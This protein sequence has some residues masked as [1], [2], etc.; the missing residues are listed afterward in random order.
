MLKY[1]KENNLSLWE[2]AV[3]YECARGNVDKT[4]VFEKMQHIVRL[5]K[6]SIQK[7]LQGTDYQDRILPVQ[8]LGFKDKMDEKAL[9]NSGMLNT[10]ILYVTAMME[11]KSSMG[12]IVAAPTAGSCGA[13]PGTLIGASDIMQKSENELVKAM[14]AAGMIGVFISEHSTFAAEVGGCQAECGA[15]SSMAAAGLVTLAGGT[16]EQ[17]IAAASSLFKILWE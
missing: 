6:E 14:L 9:L 5:M 7:G 4:A 3:L 17:C 8:S 11:M 13:L 16:L 1:G 2:L 10:I 12:I 15:G